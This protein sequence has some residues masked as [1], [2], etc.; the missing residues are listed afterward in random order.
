MQSTIKK[1]ELPYDPKTDLTDEERRANARFCREK[2]EGLREITFALPSWE[3]KINPSYKGEPTRG[4]SSWMELYLSHGN[5]GEK[6]LVPIRNI[7]FQVG[8]GEAATAKITGC[9]YDPT[10]GELGIAGIELTAANFK[11]E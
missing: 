2:A 10:N 4:D 3:V 5:H 7:W 6:F 8:A 9:Y 11:F 1:I